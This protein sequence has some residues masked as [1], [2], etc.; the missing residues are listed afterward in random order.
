MT[1][2][3]LKEE[4]FNKLKQFDSKPANKRTQADVDQ[5]NNAVNNMNAA[6]D[7]FNKVNNELN[8]HRNKLVND[9]ENAVKKYMDNY[10]LRQQR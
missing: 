5:F 9:W 8:K 6:G 10:M 1:D 2:F 4:S 3:F 7:F